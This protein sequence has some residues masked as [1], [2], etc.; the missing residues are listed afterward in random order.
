MGS[1]KFQFQTNTQ[2]AL[3]WYLAECREMLPG[4][5]LKSGGKVIA[6]KAI[7]FDGDKFYCM[8]DVETDC[9]AVQLFRVDAPRITTGVL[10]GI[11]DTVQ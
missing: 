2:Q 6:V 3:S 9:G 8:C 5:I 10:T 7:E 4:A 11:A 1:I